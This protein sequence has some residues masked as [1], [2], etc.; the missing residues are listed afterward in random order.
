MLINSK[1]HW[2]YYVVIKFVLVRSEVFPDTPV[3]S[4]NKFVRHDI[5]LYVVE[6]GIQKGNRKDR[7]S[8]GKKENEIIEMKLFCVNE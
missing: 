7:Q 5:T 8:N 3:S 2:K 1:A 6:G 4:T